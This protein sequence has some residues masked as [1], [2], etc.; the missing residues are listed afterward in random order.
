[1]AASGKWAC[2]SE[3]DCLMDIT[4][5]G[6]IYVSFREKGDFYIPADG[7]VSENGIAWSFDSADGHTECS[8][9]YN[10]EDFS[11]LCGKIKYTKTAEEAPAESEVEFTK[12]TD[13]FTVGKY[14]HYT[15]GEQIEVAE[16]FGLSA[17]QLIGTWSSPIPYDCNM[18]FYEGEKN[19]VKVL[20]SFSKGEDFPPISVWIEDGR[21][22][23]QINDCN[24]Q[25]ICNVKLTDDGCLTG[26]YTQ[27][28]HNKF[29]EV[30]FKKISDTPIK[31]EVPIKLPDKSRLELL[32]E[33]AKYGESLVTEF[34]IYGTPPEIL[35]KYGYS[36]YINGKSGDD[37]AF[38]CL[39]F[40]CDNFHHYGMSGMP[41][42]KTRRVEDMVNYCAEHENKT[43]CRGLSIMLAGIL[44]YNGITAQHVTC[45][46]YEEPFNDCH[47]VVDCLLPSGKRIMLD[48]TYRL[49]L[50]DTSGEYVSLPKLREMLISDTELIPCACARY[51]GGG[52]SNDFD[53]NSYR[54]Y[55]SKNT[56]RF[57]KGRINEDGNDEYQSMWLFPIGYPYEKTCDIHSDTILFDPDTFWKI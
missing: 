26:T 27:L 23:W 14:H 29:E 28:F 50:Y 2:I 45:Q 37:L 4:D 5:E 47:V 32:K 31:N 3:N 17:A 24:N 7:T 42:Y 57:S 15:Q 20:L 6:K 13:D 36:S 55:M 35:E 1:M 22:I 33:Y 49:W 56:F 48:P 52:E 19:K 54:E 16:D 11:K 44:R 8:L 39:D 51:N 34:K 41:S 10:N 9:A 46:P 43:N 25:G 53:I 30:K 12:M 38:A 21:L 40:I 18:S